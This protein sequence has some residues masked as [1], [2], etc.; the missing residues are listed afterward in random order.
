LSNLDLKNFKL[1]STKKHPRKHYKNINN[2]ISNLK[3]IMK[4]QNQMS[5]KKPS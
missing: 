5:F 4:T 3:I 2:F 1:F